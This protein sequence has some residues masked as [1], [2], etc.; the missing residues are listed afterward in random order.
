M[1]KTKQQIIQKAFA[2]FMTLEYREVT[3][4]RI[5]KATGLSKGGFYHYFESKEALFEEVVE[6]FFFSTVSDKAFQPDSSKSFVENMDLFLEQKEV[7]FKLFAQHL[8]VEHSEINFFMFIMHAIQQLPGARQKTALYMQQEKRQLEGIIELALQKGELAAH[9]QPNRL[10]GL[11]MRLFDG[12][13]MHGVLL[14]ESFQTL[15]RERQMVRDIF[16]WI[17]NPE[18][19]SETV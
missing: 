4:S 17:Q 16:Q 11:L 12:T 3:M 9:V 6:Q 13:E 1:T 19:G 10:A 2:L 5:L 15:S 14:N 18:H 8:G 7:A